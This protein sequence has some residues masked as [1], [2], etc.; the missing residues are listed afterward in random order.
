MPYPLVSSWNAYA[1]P[2]PQMGRTLSLDLFFTD[3]GFE[4]CFGWERWE[5]WGLAR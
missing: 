5:R 1:I 2:I 4:T 3:T